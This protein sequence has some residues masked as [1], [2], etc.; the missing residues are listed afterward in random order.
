M[1]KL[2][3]IHLHDDVVLSDNEMK[4]VLGGSGST[5]SSCSAK[6]GDKT[7]AIDHCNGKCEAVDE[8]YVKCIGETQTWTKSCNKSD[9]SGALM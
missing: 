7:M 4:K 2:G 3:R 8:E 6:C 5:E 9:G 1:R